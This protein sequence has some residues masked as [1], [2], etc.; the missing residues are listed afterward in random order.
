MIGLAADL[1][2]RTLSASLNGTWACAIAG[3]QQ[4]PQQQ[5]RRQQQQPSLASLLAVHPCF[6]NVDLSRGVR[7]AVTVAGAAAVA[8]NFGQRPFLFA[9]PSTRF[10]P[11]AEADGTCYCC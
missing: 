10:R 4:Q 6:R 3:A 8:L 2:V 1:S 7:P 5:Q 11:V 9:P